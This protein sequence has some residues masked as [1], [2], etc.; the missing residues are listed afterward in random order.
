MKNLKLLLIL[1][2]GIALS[3]ATSC[4]KDD[5]D[6]DD[7]GGGENPTS[8]TCYIKKQTSDD[9][10]YIQYSYDANHKLKVYEEH[11]STGAIGS[12]VEFAYNSDGTLAKFQTFD[13]AGKLITKMV[14]SYVGG[15]ISE[16]ELFIDMGN[17][18]KS[19]A[20]YL[21]TFSANHLSKVEMKM[22]VLGT[23]T[24][25]VAGKKEFAYTGDNPTTVT[26]YTFD[27]GSMSLKKSSETE[28]VYDDKKN[29]I[30]NVGIDYMFYD[31]Q[32]IS[33]NNYTKMTVKDDHGA[34][35]KDASENVT[36]EYNASGYPTKATSSN[37]SGNR[38]GVMIMEYNC[39]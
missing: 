24:P 14:Y 2:M 32:F 10:S 15:K 26:E 20:V 8:E 22:D 27:A 11:D 34:I 13:D 17:G 38:G 35:D 19:F 31:V 18:L 25:I 30:H 39:I 3:V 5:D 37:L 6:N 12:K 28:Y 29:P 9:G 1:L 23:G 36:F 33:K 7:N 4:N 16:A 21:Y